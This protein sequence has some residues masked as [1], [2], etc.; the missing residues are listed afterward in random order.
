MIHWKSW[1]GLEMKPGGSGIPA[2]LKT[3]Y[4]EHRVVR[5]KKDKF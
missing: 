1:C 2:L 4:H 5:L 3:I